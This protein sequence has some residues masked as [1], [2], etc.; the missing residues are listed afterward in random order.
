MSAGSNPTSLT[1]SL[2]LRFVQVDGLLRM[3]SPLFTHARIVLQRHCESPEEQRSPIHHAQLVRK[4]QYPILPV[5]LAMPF[6]IEVLR[7]EGA[8]HEPAEFREEPSRV[9]FSLDAQVAEVV[10]HDFVRLAVGD[11]EYE[12]RNP[13]PLVLVETLHL[14][15][16]DYIMRPV[17][18]FGQRQVSLKTLLRVSVPPRW[19]FWATW[20][21]GIH[22][23]KP[24]FGRF[25]GSLSSWTMRM[26]PG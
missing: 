17:R 12:F 10:G 2:S 22:S 15:V 5:Q 25:D 20:Y 13:N 3:M 8:E 14:T 19:Q 26:L 9:G 24:I 7:L 18:D 1:Q 23:L 11:A 21:C 6:V 4:V 16:V